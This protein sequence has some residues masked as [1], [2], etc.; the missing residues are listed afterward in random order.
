M[1]RTH[2]GTTLFFWGGATQNRY[3]SFVKVIQYLNVWE[4]IELLRK[5]MKNNAWTS[6]ISVRWRK[7]EMRKGVFIWRMWVGKGK[8]KT[9]HV[10]E[11]TAEMEEAGIPSKNQG[12]LFPNATFIA[13]KQGA[14]HFAGIQCA[15]GKKRE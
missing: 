13:K 10:R 6:K 2:P 3:F 11:E 15:R 12:K 5:K 9:R 1:T 4:G 7:D 8:R 14:G